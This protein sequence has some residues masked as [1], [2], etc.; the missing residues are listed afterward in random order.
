MIQCATSPLQQTLIQNVRK[1]MFGVPVM[2][3]GL[4]PFQRGM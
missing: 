1:Q 4:G 2:P 3:Q